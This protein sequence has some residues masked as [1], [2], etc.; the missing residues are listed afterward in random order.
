[1]VNE[2]AAPFPIPQPA[3][4]RHIKVLAEAGLIVRRVDGTRRFDA[5]PAEVYRADLAPPRRT[6]HVERMHRP[7]PTPD[8]H[9]VTTF[10][11]DHA[12]T[13]MPSVP[14][15]LESLTRDSE[16]KGGSTQ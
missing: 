1:M 3:I 11:P 7:D 10:A 6:V 16:P 8:N 15:P 4:S 14:R 5:S 2:L 13:P 9:V 12:G